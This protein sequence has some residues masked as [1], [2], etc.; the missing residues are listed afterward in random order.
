MGQLSSLACLITFARGPNLLT[1][2]PA[3]AR[4]AAIA[5]SHGDNWRRA[6]TSHGSSSFSELSPV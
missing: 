5:L 3:S 4:L 6:Q 2:L 1:P